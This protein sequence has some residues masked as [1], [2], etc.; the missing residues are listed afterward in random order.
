MQSHFLQLQGY[1]PLIESN[2]CSSGWRHL[3]VALGLIDSVPATIHPGLLK[4]GEDALL[5][6]LAARAA[7]SLMQRDILP[8]RPQLGASLR[9]L[10]YQ[11]QWVSTQRCVPVS[12]PR[13][14]CCGCCKILS[15]PSD[16]SSSNGI[17]SP[18]HS[19]NHSF[20]HS[21]F[22]FFP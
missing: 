17:S 13:S 21:I 16:L 14:R 8:L 5:E 6:P 10:T 19:F 15:P 4:R 7:G 3:V 22:L 20:I 2:F 11:E 12:M 1:N 18:S 9:C